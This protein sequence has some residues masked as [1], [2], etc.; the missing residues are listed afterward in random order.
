MERMQWFGRVSE[1]V[2]ILRDEIS[3]SEKGCCG[4]FG[5]KVSL[6]DLLPPLKSPR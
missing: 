3:Q 2:V 4:V 5:C 6:D 1:R